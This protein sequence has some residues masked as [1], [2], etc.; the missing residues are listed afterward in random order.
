MSHFPTHAG[1]TSID[2]P[3]ACVQYLLDT[4]DGSKSGSGLS[5]SLETPRQGIGQADVNIALCKY[6]GKRDPKLN[7]PHNSSLSITLPALGTQTQVTWSPSPSSTGLQHLTF[8]GQVLSPEHAT[9]QR[10]QQFLDWFPMA[11]RGQFE[12]VTDNSV[13]TAAGLASSASGYAALVLAL[14]QTF[15]WAL[16][17]T[18]LSIL[19]RLGSGSATRSLY[20][21]F[22]VWNKGERL[23]GLDSYAYPLKESWPGLRIGLVEVDTSQKPIG[24]TQGMQATTQTCALYQQWPQQAEADLRTLTTAIEARD[25]AT[26]GRT[27]EH[28][29]LSM[30]ATMIATWP[31]IVYWQSQT[32]EAM[33]TVWALRAQGVAVYFTMDAGPNLKLLYLQ[34]DQACIQN[35]FKGLIEIQPF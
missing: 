31:P 15:G 22:A 2:T 4:A 11:H 30:H 9:F 21:G 34:K 12:V 33:Q 10:T 14:N 1:A 7:L 20:P 24:S 3:Q 35:A 16:P 29:A 13:P 23:D 18:T 19:A 26:L 28:N 17:A 25:F 6:W 32:L 8:N 5:A 27:A